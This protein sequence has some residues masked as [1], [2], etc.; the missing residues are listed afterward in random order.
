MRRL[1]IGLCVGAILALA[2]TPALGSPP[3][4][5]QEATCAKH[6][7]KKNAPKFCE[8]EVVIS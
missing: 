1:R 3:P 8:E 6:E 7:G 4:Q 5:K 2:A